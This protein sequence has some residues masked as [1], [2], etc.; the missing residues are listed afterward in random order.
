MSQVINQ[1]FNHIIKPKHRCIAWEPLELHVYCVKYSASLTFN[2]ISDPFLSIIVPLFLRNKVKSVTIITQNSYGVFSTKWQYFE[3]TGVF[4][5]GNKSFFKTQCSNCLAQE[6]NPWKKC[7]VW[8]VI[9]LLYL[10]YKERQNNKMYNQ[11][12]PL[13]CVVIYRT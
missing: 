1:R 11:K 5:N 2:S 6:L 10:K 13:S 3:D 12:D 8:K 4:R 9:S 7:F